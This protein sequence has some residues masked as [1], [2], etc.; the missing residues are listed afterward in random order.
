MERRGP[1][2]PRRLPPS[3]YSFAAKAASA[4]TADQNGY[5]NSNR[6][7]L[8][9]TV[10]KA[11]ARPHRIPPPWRPRRPPPPSP[12]SRTALTVAAAAH[13]RHHKFNCIYP[14]ICLLR[15]AVEIEQWGGDNSSSS[16]QLVSIAVVA[17]VEG[18]DRSTDQSPEEL[19]RQFCS[20]KNFGFDFVIC[21]GIWKL[22][23]E[24]KRRVGLNNGSGIFVLK[25]GNLDDRNDDALNNSSWFELRRWVAGVH[26]TAQHLPGWVQ[27][28]KRIT[29][30]MLGLL[31]QGRVGSGRVGLIELNDYWVGQMG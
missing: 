21:V 4:L 1:P 26:P 5:K 18:R 10:T 20:R 11:A 24:G 30:F 7:R 13:L 31:F 28:D 22:V 6:R 23:F 3:S 29:W 12:P 15:H 14:K 2:P 19:G 8:V 27:R 16:C 9:S 17:V 25:F